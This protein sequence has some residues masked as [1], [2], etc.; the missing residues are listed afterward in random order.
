IALIRIQWTGPWTKE[1]SNPR[2]AYT[3][4]HWIAGW[5][6]R[7]FPKMR[8]FDVNGGIRALVWWFQQ[9]VPILIPS[10]GDG[11]FFPTHIWGLK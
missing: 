7:E 6:D 9:I 4:T 3:H 8:V 5:I 10:G 1:G 2:W 11:G